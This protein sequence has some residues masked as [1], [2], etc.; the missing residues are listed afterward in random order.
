MTCSDLIS[1]G[2]FPENRTTYHPY[3][4]EDKE[5]N[6]ITSAEKI[7]YKLSD[8]IET[9]VDWSEINP[10]TAPGEL[11]I[12]ADDNIIDDS[13]KRF[14]TFKVTHN[15]GKQITKTILYVL[16]NSVNI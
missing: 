1:T 6:P 16:E 9:L 11:E 4:F 12:P 14:L 7:E 8:G 15:G 3:S 13:D 2:T 5:G 10:P